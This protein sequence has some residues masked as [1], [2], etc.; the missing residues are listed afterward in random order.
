M[1]RVD[2]CVDFQKRQT[3]AD[4]TENKNYKR[5]KSSQLDGHHLHVR[6]ST[7]LFTS[8]SS[9]ARHHADS[10]SG[11]SVGAVPENHSVLSQQSHKK[12][13]THRTLQKS[14]HRETHKRTTHCDESENDKVRCRQ[15]TSPDSH[16]DNRSVWN[17]NEKRDHE[18]SEEEEEED[19]WEEEALMLERCLTSPEGKHDLEFSSGWDQKC[20]CGY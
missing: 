2:L 16:L 6:Y 15:D 19:D 9:K 3:E 1:S 14:H 8:D 4:V 11:K 20:H 5:I 10:E 17:K 12:Q 13:K 18:S 7:S